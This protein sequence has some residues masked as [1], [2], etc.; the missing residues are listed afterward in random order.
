MINNFSLQSVAN[1]EL[2]LLKSIKKERNQFKRMRIHE[3][4][5][6]MISHKL[7]SLIRIIL[8]KCELFLKNIFTLI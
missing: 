1:I 4:F 2:K 8:L 7:K 5:G 6:K 3:L